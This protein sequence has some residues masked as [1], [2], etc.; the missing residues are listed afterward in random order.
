LFWTW[1]CAVSG[2]VPGRNVTLMLAPPCDVD[3]L[4]K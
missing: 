2:F 4:E 3:E 1:T